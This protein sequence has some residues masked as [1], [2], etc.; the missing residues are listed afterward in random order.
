[1]KR[2]RS[3][4]CSAGNCKLLP[5]AASCLRVAHTACPAA[6]TCTHARLACT[7]PQWRSTP[8]T[9][10]PLVWTSWSERWT[11]ALDFC[12]GA[13]RWE[14]ICPRRCV[15]V[16]AVLQVWPPPAPALPPGGAYPPTHHHHHHHPTACPRLP[17]SQVQTALGTIIRNANARQ[18]PCSVFGSFG[19]SGEAV[20]M[21]EK[22]LKVGGPGWL[23]RW[24]WWGGGLAWLS[25][26]LGL[27]V[28]CHLQTCRF[29]F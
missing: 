9:W 21:M 11:A 8:S 12:W 14:G 19:W 20:D 23:G 2:G 13:P 4:P 26:W 3:G 29:R 1:M 25:W 24:W 16:T 6:N 5:C 18:V 22:R 7:S 10:R 17:P 27:C 15:R 28:A